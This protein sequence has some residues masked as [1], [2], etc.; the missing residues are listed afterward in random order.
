MSINTKYYLVLLSSAFIGVATFITTYLGQTLNIE[1]RNDLLFESNTLFI[2]LFIYFILARKVT[3]NRLVKTGFLLLIFNQAYDVV[4]EIDVLDR[5]A[6]SNDFLHSLIEDG[7]LQIAYLLIA[8]GITRLINDMHNRATI[9]E[10][11]GL[12]NRKKLSEIELDTFDLI[13]FD[14]D[15]LKLVNDSEGHSAGD[16]LIIRFAHGLKSS[17]PNQ[18]SAYRIGGDEFVAVVPVGLS[19]ELITNLDKQLEKRAV[20]Y[21]YGIEP[22]T[23]REKFKEAL[24]KTDQA[25][26][27]MKNSQRTAESLK[28]RKS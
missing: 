27:Q 8:F 2:L 5:W 15:G 26:Y 12:Y 1:S 21:S 7:S 10:L 3:T 16:R 17:L 28:Q 22:Q 6:D 13:Y 11:T 23:R 25:M 18:G 4:T 24:I 20:S 19:D 14:L 9:D